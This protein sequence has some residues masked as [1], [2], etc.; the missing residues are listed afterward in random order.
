[1]ILQLNTLFAQIISTNALVEPSFFENLVRGVVGMT[2]IVFI[3]W[4]ASTNR[5]AINW[6]TAGIGLVLQLLIAIGI[7]YIPFIQSIFEIVGKMFIKV[8]DF[9]RDGST[10]LLGD[11]VNLNKTGYIFAFQILPTIVF[12]SGIT[13]L[14]FYLGVIQKIVYFLALGMTVITSYSIH[15]TKLYE[16]YL[17]ITTEFTSDV[18]CD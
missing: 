14:L 8:L 7:L 18:R 9:T 11:L 2:T 12:F 5:K 15:Y 6:K 3:A 17:R 4:L 1:M 13:S 10:F 16:R